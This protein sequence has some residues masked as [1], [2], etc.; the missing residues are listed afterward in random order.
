[1]DGFKIDENG[2][3]IVNDTDIEL[4]NNNE[5]IAQTVRQ[6]LKT[7]L[8]EWWLNEDEGIDLYSML[9]KNPNYDQIEDNVKNALLQVDNTFELLTFEHT[10]NNRKLT[11]NFTA[12][13]ENGEE[14]EV[15][16]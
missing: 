4:T 15:T 1:M 6:I 10:Y 11:I 5:L 12:R 7:N 8:G 9:C 13:N 3:V 16:L 14:I 2:D